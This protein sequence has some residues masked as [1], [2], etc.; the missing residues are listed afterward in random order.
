MVNGL[1][2]HESSK[3]TYCSAE[4]LTQFKTKDAS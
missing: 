3:D 1:F 2:L 4:L